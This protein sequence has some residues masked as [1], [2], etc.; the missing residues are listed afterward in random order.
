MHPH[1]DEQSLMN[2]LQEGWDDISQEW[3]N[4]LVESMPK[5]LL[6]VIRLE[7]GMTGY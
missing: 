4:E 7:G 6:D 2:I 5:R 3:I 1:W